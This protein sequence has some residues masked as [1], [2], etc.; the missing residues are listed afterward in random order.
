[1]ASDD[2]AAPTLLLEVSLRTSGT[3][4]VLTYPELVFTASGESRAIGVACRV[5]LLSRSCPSEALS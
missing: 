4:L 2:D 3:M 5:T 1:M